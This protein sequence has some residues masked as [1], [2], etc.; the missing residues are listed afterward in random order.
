MHTITHIHTHIHAYQGGEV[1]AGRQREY[2][3]YTLPLGAE[4]MADNLGLELLGDRL[5]LRVDG[6]NHH[7]VCVCVCVWIL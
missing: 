5:G 1:H 2:A 3:R 7:C 4:T 6:L